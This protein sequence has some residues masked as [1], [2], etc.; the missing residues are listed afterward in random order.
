MTADQAAQACAD[1]RWGHLAAPR[2][3]VCLGGHPCVELPGWSRQEA[4]GRYLELCGIT[5]T[6]FPPA[7]ELVE[8]YPAALPEYGLK[9][10][11]GGQ[12]GGHPAAGL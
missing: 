8:D 6:V 12:P 7:A 11:D 9:E 3:R 10:L 5:A 2:W 1:R 4:I